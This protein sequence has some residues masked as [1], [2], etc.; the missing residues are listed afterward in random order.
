MSVTVILG[1]I[2]F[3]TIVLSTMQHS[4]TEYIYHQTD[5]RNKN[6]F[7]KSNVDRMNKTPDGF[8]NHIKSRPS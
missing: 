5:D 1:V 2:M 7:V 3:V 8:K 6:G 4:D